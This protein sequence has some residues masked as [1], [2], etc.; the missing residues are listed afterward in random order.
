VISARLKAVILL[1]LELDDFDITDA[2]TANTVPGWD[3]LRHA[4]VIAAV[5]AEYGIRLKTLEVLRLRSVGDL[6]KLVDSK[7]AT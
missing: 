4:Q 3:S 2:T 7:Q 1:E 6:Q 5:E